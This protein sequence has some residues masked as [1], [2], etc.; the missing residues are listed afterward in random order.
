MRSAISSEH[1]FVGMV[2]MRKVLFC[3]TVHYIYCNV[4]NIGL[5]MYEGV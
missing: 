2:K 4:S 5:Y 1:I 3:T